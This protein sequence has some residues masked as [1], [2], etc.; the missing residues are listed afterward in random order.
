MNY[1]K[2]SS[3]K[4]MNATFN[5]SPCDLLIVIAKQTLIGNCILLVGRYE[6]YARYKN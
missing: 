2:Q 5:D 6:G 4:S 3:L 1:E